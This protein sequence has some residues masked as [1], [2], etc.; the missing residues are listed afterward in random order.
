MFYNIKSKYNIS[1]AIS[2]RMSEIYKN[3]L[4]VVWQ[5]A[6]SRV[7][8]SARNQKGMNVGKIMENAVKGFGSGGGHEAAAGAT[9]DVKDW[10]KFRENVV[11]LAV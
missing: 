1:S 9:M 7:K 8:V 6:G 10:E 11:R 4:I 5:K 2:T 3:R